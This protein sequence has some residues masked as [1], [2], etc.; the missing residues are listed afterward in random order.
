MSHYETIYALVSNPRL[1]QPLEFKQ[2]H[3]LI[4]VE[5][6]NRDVLRL[7]YPQ[8]KNQ[9][10]SFTRLIPPHPL[11]SHEDLNQA[12]CYLAPKMC[13]E[14]YHPLISSLQ[15]LSFIDLDCNPSLLMSIDTYS[16]PFFQNKVWI[17]SNFSLLNSFSLD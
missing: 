6:G 3:A 2:L 11:R 1:N 9:L 4:L 7:L 5:R 16:L 17:Q 12:L 13:L 10:S 14:E 15:S 8:P